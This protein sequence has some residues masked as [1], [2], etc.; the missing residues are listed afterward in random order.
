MTDGYSVWR[1]L[2]KMTNLGCWAH[3]RRKFKDALDLSPKKTGQAKQALSY[4]QKL[5]AI[6]NK[7]QFLSVAERGKKKVSGS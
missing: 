3:A 1:M 6:E 2:K 5:Y 7:A 4:I